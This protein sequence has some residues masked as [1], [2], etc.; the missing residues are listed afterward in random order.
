MSSN[1]YGPPSLVPL[2]TR[3]P[4][5]TSDKRHPWMGYPEETPSLLRHTYHNFG[6]CITYELYGTSYQ[7]KSLIKGEGPS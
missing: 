2:G 6:L 4:G 7:Y 5:G 1:T 3:G